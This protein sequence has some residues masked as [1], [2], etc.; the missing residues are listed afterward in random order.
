MASISSLACAGFPAELS[1]A[2]YALALKLGGA[3]APSASTARGRRAS[4]A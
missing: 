3:L 1:G 2:A 4:G